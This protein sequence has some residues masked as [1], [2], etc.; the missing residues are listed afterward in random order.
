MVKALLLCQLS[1]AFGQ[2][3]EQLRPH[4]QN[5]MSSQSLHSRT[6]L[7]QTRHTRPNANFPPRTWQRAPT[8]TE[9]PLQRLESR[10]NPPAASPRLRSA[11]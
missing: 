2:D 9:E 10:D 11:F 7:L 8:A 1:L 6:C 5:V 4:P 3:P